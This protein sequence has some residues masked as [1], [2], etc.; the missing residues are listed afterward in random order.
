MY[1]DYL[2]TGSMDSLMF[3]PMLSADMA[4]NSDIIRKNRWFENYIGYLYKKA[5]N[6]R[7]VEKEFYY[8]EF[9]IKYALQLTEGTAGNE[10]RADYYNKR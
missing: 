6:Y 8:A 9:S 2:N 10:I 5:S 1:R 7:Q 3:L 4:E